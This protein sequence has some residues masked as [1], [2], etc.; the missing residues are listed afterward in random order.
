[1][2]FSAGIA[3]PEADQFMVGQVD[4]DG[5]YQI[6]NLTEALKHVTNFDCAIDGGAHVGLWSK[7]MAWNFKR[8]IAVEPSPDTFEALVWNLGERGFERSMNVECRNV[9]L[10]DKPG[11]VSMHLQPDQAQRA[12]TG[13]RFVK[14]GGAIPV[15]TIDSWHLESLGFLKLDIEGSEPL[16][17]KGAEKTLKRCRPVVLFENKHLW[18]HNLGLPKNAVSKLLESVGYRFAAQVSRDQIWV[19]R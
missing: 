9:A 12:N 11:M 4:K 6:E 13:A 3:F 15:E 5:L 1:M 2:K 19:A 18:T 8:V 10:G 16:A 14:P 17:L 7:V